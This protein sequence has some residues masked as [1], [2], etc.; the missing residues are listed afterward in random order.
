MPWR[1][2]RVI[3]KF[4]R[5]DGGCETFAARYDLLLHSSKVGERFDLPL[6][7]TCWGSVSHA[8][9]RDKCLEQISY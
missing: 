4:G 2:E 6:D 3:R 8:R 5:S 1:S 7:T 9:P